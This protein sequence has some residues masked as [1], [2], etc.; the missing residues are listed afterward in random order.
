MMITSPE[1]I[2]VNVSTL[3]REPIGRKR[4]AD[5]GNRFVG[6]ESESPLQYHYQMA[7]VTLG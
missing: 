2:E 1:E 3:K 6:R 4:T 7:H 5:A